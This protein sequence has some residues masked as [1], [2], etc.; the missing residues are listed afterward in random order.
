MIASDKSFNDRGIRVIIFN[1]KV[2]DSRK[3]LLFPFCPSCDQKRTILY[4]EY[5]AEELLLELPH[6]QFVFTV[7]KI[8]RVC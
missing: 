2:S 5:L 1:G 3:I 7:P 8:L 4:A 6:R